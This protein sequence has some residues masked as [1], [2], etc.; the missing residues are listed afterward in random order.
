MY[1]DSELVSC[2]GAMYAI[3][4]PWVLVNGLLVCC[5]LCRDE[6][7]DNF[8]LGYGVMANMVVSLKKWDQRHKVS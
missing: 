8:E 2:G 7:S 1:Y 5:T 4:T 6:E 3:C